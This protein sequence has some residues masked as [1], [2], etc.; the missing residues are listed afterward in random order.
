MQ[1][2]M[3][4]NIRVKR[5][6]AQ[7]VCF[8]ILLM[9]GGA[10]TQVPDF[11]AERAW[12][13]LLAQCA[14]GPRP[15]G[16]EAHL[17]CLE[18]LED[19]LKKLAPSVQRQPFM[20]V[21]PVSG[22]S[23]SFVNLIAGY[24]PERSRRVLLCAHW[25]TRPWADRDPDPAN[26]DSPILG[27][28][29]GASGVAILLE[30]ARH[31]ARKDPGIGVDIVLFDGED[32]GRAGHYDEYC[33]GSTWYAQNLKYPLPEAAVLLDMVGD[34]DLCIPQELYSRM[35]APQLLSEIFL[36]A[37]ELGE[38]TFDPR[39]GYAVYDDHVPLLQEGIQA[40]NLIDFDFDFWHTLRDVPEN[41]SAQSL[42]SVGRVVLA[43]I[44][45]RGGRE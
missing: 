22:K 23:H 15:P 16:S 45:R 19:E 12:K 29:D 30:I 9:P 21:D 34:A 27:A 44:Y 37:E 20:G 39:S 31:L 33:L 38:N 17:R 8:L 36:I 7:G 42:K 32:M 3:P 2:E 18:Y 4:A 6:I 1:L 14:F 41:C 5:T 40:V 35:S 13:Y 24:W 10:R 25:D 26:R 43:W 11:D 28:N